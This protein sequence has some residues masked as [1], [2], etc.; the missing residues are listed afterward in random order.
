MFVFGKKFEGII[1]LVAL[2]IW[3][4]VLVGAVALIVGKDLAL[5]GAVGMVSWV[6]L[7]SRSIVRT[8]K[9]YWSSRE[10]GHWGSKEEIVFL[11]MRNLALQVRRVLH[12]V[13]PIVVLVGFVSLMKYYYNKE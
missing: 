5:L 11:S 2:A 7:T 8:G 4:G 12:K 9:T 1:N 6:V 13:N 10:R 3:V